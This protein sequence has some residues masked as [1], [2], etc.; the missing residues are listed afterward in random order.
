MCL[1]LLTRG[2]FFGI[3]VLICFVWRLLSL[4]ISDETL[5]L[6]CALEYIIGSSCYNPNSYN[7]YTGEQGRIFAIR[8]GTAIGLTEKYGI[9]KNLGGWMSLVHFHKAY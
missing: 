7:G 3:I 6:V 5:E 4:K 2:I 1:I 8:F 9:G